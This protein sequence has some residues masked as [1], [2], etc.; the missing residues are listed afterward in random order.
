MQPSPSRVPWID[1]LR[2][3]LIIFVVAIHACLPYTTFPVFNKQFYTDSTHP[4]VDTVN[5]K[6]IDITEDFMELFLMCLMF[7]ISGIFIAKSLQGKGTKAF[8]RDRF[9]R[10]FIPFVIS[11]TLIMLITYYPSYRLAY[12]KSNFI[13][14]TIDFFTV[15]P[16]PI[17]PP[18]FL[19]ILFVFNII[20]ALC[21]PLVSK[22]VNR[23]GQ[24]L[25]RQKQHPWKVLLFLFVLTWL[26][27]VP[28][29]LFVNPGEW[30]RFGPFAYQTSKPLLYFSYFFI[31]ILIGVAGLYKGILAEGTQVTRW[32]PV[33]V[34]G[35]CCLF[36]VMKLSESP[37]TR[38]VNEKSL[39]QLQATLIYRSVWVLCC[40]LAC[41]GCLTLF[42]RIFRR[43][44]ARWSA[45][46][47][48]AYGIYLVH[49]IFVIWCQYWLLCVDLP[50][51]AKFLLTTII[52]VLV[53][54]WVSH[55]LRKIKVIGRY[56]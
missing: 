28:I 24:F 41:I 17:A 37:L 45:F 44:S 52:A 21:Y 12:G 39:S 48:N 5:W 49:Y 33:W 35:Y 32:W 23:L 11:V 16:W 47:A 20:F 6:G 18:W 42:M 13:D 29:V 46:S 26:C 34:A 56:L 3:F 4:I 50:A 43:P 15:Q 7:L 27:Y 19:W 14:Y 2:G 36:I 38:L 51:V 31:G 53:S 55:L 30:T 10:L 40:A 8:M 25:A 22:Q 9:F 1:Y 54:W